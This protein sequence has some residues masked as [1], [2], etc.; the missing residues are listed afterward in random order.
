MSFQNV[1][2]EENFHTRG[3]YPLP[4]SIGRKLPTMSEG[5]SEI[6]QP[7]D[8]RGGCDC[9]HVVNVSSDGEGEAATDFGVGRTQVGVLQRAACQHR[10]L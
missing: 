6:S 1:Q 9:L 3:V 8:Q 5:L 2:L 7:L 10:F 4:G